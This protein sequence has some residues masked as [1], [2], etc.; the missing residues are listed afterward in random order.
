MK[1]TIELMSR[2]DL[3]FC[4]EQAR[5]EGWNPGLHDMDVFYETDPS[6]WFKAVDDQGRIIGSISAVAYDAQFGFV[7]FFV[8]RPE[9]RGGRVG[10]E[11]GG[12]AF[13]HL[14]GRVIGQDGVFAKVANYETW[15]FELAYRNLRYEW[16]D[17]SLPSDPG[18]ATQPYSPDMR[19]GILAFDEGL[20]PCRRDSFLKRWLAMPEAV[21]RTSVRDGK[22][23]GWGLRRRCVSGWKI[24][25]LLAGDA[26]TAAALLRDLLAGAEPQVPVYLDVP[27]VNEDAVRLA[28]SF[29]MKQCFGTARMYKNGM[30]DL[31]V[32]RL[33]GVTSFELG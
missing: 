15:G 32:S 31:D 20:F 26:V 9:W 29:G 19:S 7:G 17:G 6:G 5:R 23:T 18:V 30:P 1:T 27:E 22:L 2:G 13:E 10:L 21:I 24:G 28:E 11:L 3:E 25:P 4:A 33:F 12:A 14:G 8:V 16:R